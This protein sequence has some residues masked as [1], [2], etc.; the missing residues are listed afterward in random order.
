MRVADLPV[1]TCQR[2]SRSGADRL[3]FETFFRGKRDG[4]FVGGAELQILAALDLD[5]FRI[6]VL[7]VESV[8]Q[9]EQIARLLSE[10]GYQAVGRVGEDAVFRR[11][12]VKPLP[13][14]SVLCAVWHADPGRER[15]LAAHAA[16]LAAQSVPV[17]PIYIF[18]AGDEPPAGLPG[19]KVVAHEPL[20]IFERYL[21]WRGLCIEPQPAAFARLRAR[22][23]CFCEEVAVADFE[24]EGL[25]LEGGAEDGQRMLGGLQYAAAGDP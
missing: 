5:R 15:L 12:D 17:E 10:R 22:R 7:V 4:I 11:G 24:G 3:L 2:F 14:T 21:G 6:G 8:S 1:P 20:T 16:N 9:R 18:D 23:Q 13:R 25:L 19:R